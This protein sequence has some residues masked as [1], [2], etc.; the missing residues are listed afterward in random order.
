MPR[1]FLA[2]ALCCALPALLA[3][4]AGCRDR[5]PAPSPA[6]PHAAPPSPRLVPDHEG[7]ALETLHLIN[8]HEIEMGKLAQERGGAQAVKDHGAMLVRDHRDA[9]V[10]VV[11]HATRT[12]HR[13]VI[14]T[15]EQHDS[16]RRGAA[17]MGGLREVGP[18]SFDHELATTMVAD[19]EKALAFL[20][21]AR[22]SVESARFRNLLAQLQPV[23]Q[24][25]L[26]AARQLAAATA[27]TATAQPG[28]A[29]SAHSRR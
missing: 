29:E 15:P 28:S 19:H 11:D 17:A 18:A 26:E 27:S 10:K 3:I 8:L 12:H 20:E 7:D 5:G 21:E 9:D 24:R 22:R 25:H 16:E 6:S 4:T 13:L 1:S 2:R 23:F 14:D